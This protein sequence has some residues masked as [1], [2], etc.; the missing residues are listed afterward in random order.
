MRS[1]FWATLSAVSSSNDYLSTRRFPWRN[2]ETPGSTSTKL[3]N[4]LAV[5]ALIVLMTQ[6]ACRPETPSGAPTPAPG[7]LEVSTISGARVRPLEVTGKASVLVFLGVECP[8]SNRYAPE[9]RRLQQKFAGEK[10]D[11]WMVYPGTNYSRDEIQEH[12]KAFELP[13]QSVIDSQLT[14][15]AATK[16]RVTPEAVVFLPGGQIAYRGRIDDRFPKLGVERREPTQRDLDEALTAILA[17][18]APASAE[19]TAVGCFIQGLP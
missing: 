7:A 1:A 13:G 14:L 18:R 3:P 2:P 15:S 12:R 17:G 8:I 5:G 6:L 9:L 19:T 16:V 10:V 11:W 4:Q